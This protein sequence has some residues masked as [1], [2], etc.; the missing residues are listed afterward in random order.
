[1][2]FCSVFLG[3]FYHESFEV[4]GIDVV[5]HNTALWILVGWLAHNKQFYTILMSAVNFGG[6]I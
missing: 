5:V 1:M 2:Y 6:M 3:A 4:I